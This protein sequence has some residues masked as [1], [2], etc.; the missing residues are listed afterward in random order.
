MKAKYAAIVGGLAILFAGCSSVKVVEV[1]YPSTTFSKVALNAK[2]QVCIVALDDDNITKSVADALS[3]SFAKSGQYS[4]TDN[5]AEADYWLTVAGACDARVDDNAAV[6]YNDM[7]IKAKSENDGGGYEYMTRVRQVS[8]GA[9]LGVRISVYEA[10]NLAPIHYLDLP[11]YASDIVS[12]T[13]YSSQRASF[14]PN[15]QLTEFLS[16]ALE[17]INDTFITRVKSIKVAVPE[18]LDPTIMSPIL[19]LANYIG[20]NGPESDCSRQ[21]SLIVAAANVFIP[22]PIEQLREKMEAEDSTIEESSIETIL[23]AYY[24]RALANEVGCMNASEL[25]QLHKEHLQILEM[26]EDMSLVY[27]CSRALSRI[28]YK[29]SHLGGNI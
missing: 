9:A 29:L 2:S 26:T 25:R 19:A 22:C 8:L 11:L 12:E 3:R 14:D 27:V 15:R 16:N 28:E 1:R 4:V 24:A 18:K 17:Q 23:G 6:K 21:K 10:G 5:R 7:V 13:T 20:S